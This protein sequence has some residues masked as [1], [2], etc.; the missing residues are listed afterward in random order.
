MTADTD[1]F[2]NA[3]LC[4]GSR[5]GHV[6]VVTLLLA[7]G[8]DPRARNRY[9]WTALIAAAGAYRAVRA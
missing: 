4:V 9:G 5:E 8:A 1:Q 3:A 6:E 7:R 2:G